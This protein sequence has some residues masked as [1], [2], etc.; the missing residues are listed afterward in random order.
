V[1][2]HVLFVDDEPIVLETL[3]R[4][5]RR[6][7]TNWK[8]TFCSDPQEAW[9][10]LLDGQVD[11]VV[12]DIA[13]PGLDGL[14]LLRRMQ[15]SERTRDI[16]VVVLTGLGDRTLKRTAL[17]LGATDL[18]SK[19]VSA[20]DLI[21]RIASVLRLKAY[22]DQLKAQTRYLEAKVREQTARLV[23]SRLEIVWRL[24]AAAEC[25][26]EDTGNHVIRVGC[27]SRALAERMSSDPVFVEN[28]FLAAPLHDVGKIGIP[29]SILR[30]PGRLTPE[31]RA[32][33]EQHCQIGAEILRKVPGVRNAFVEWYNDP[34]LDEAAEVSNPVLDTA[35][36]IALMHH[37]R[38]DGKG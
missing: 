29:D 23:Q 25:R 22:Q 9:R 34:L 10:Y 11:A 12:T 32:V 36:T 24:A 18:L 35:A 2:S 15:Q 8:M 38:W 27:V 19:P 21:A 33:M 1:K 30:K 31:E 3:R 13:M 17:Q 4:L 6:A 14:E 20:D 26:D 7:G 16:P 28:V 5:L 37:E